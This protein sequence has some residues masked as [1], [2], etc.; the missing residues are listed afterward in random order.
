MHDGFKIVSFRD[1]GNNLGSPS[2]K[3]A[4]DWE[5][6]QRHDEH[7]SLAYGVDWSFQRWQ[8]QSGQTLIASASFYDH[9][10]HIWRG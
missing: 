7:K 5:I 9:A 8:D 4:E 10:L 2:N 3:N 1:I 6:R